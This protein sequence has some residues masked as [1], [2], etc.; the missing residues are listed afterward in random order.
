MCLSKQS[1]CAK[2]MHTHIQMYTYIQFASRVK[3]SWRRNDN[4]S[5]PGGPKWIKNRYKFVLKIQLSFISISERLFLDLGSI[6]ARKLTPKWEVLGLFFRASYEYARSV[7]LNKYQSFCYVF[8]LWKRRV[9][10]LKGIFFGC[11]FECVLSQTFLDFGA[12]FG[13]TWVPRG[14]YLCIDVSVCRCIGVSV[15]LCIGVSVYWCLNALSMYYRCT[16]DV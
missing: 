14:M 3:P 15:Y 5:R 12:N 2:V 10:T 7:I 8:Q 1:M 13:A 6:L 9:S 11:F 16:I 4:K